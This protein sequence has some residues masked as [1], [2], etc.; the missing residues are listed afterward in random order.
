M[1]GVVTV[2]ELKTQGYKLLALRNNSDPE[3]A[4]GCEA[5]SDRPQLQNRECLCVV[6]GVGRMELWR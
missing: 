4:G 6:M 2:V 1:L 5:S 3:F